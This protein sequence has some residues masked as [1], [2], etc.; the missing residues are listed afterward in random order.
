MIQA[1]DEATTRAQGAA[2]SS[3]QRDV[4]HVGEG[5]AAEHDVRRARVE[6]GQFF[7]AAQHQVDVDA[8][9]RSEPAGVGD[10]HLAQVDARNAG[11]L[12]GKGDA[13]LSAATT[14]VEDVQGGHVAQQL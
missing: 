11:T 7:Q 4:G 14:Q 5:V 12:P 10:L 2:H 3:R 8:L 6:R 13:V 9:R 1:E